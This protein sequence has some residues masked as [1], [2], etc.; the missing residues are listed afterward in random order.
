MIILRD[1]T[2][3]KKAQETLKNANIE[4]E[5]RVRE[6]TKEL[7]SLIEQSPLGIVIYNRKGNITEH[8]KSFNEILEITDESKIMF[9]NIFSDDYLIRNNYYLQLKNI[10]EEGGSL[11]TR[12]I[13]IS[14]FE[15]SIYQ[16]NNP[17]WLKFRFYSIQSNDEK[18]QNVIGIIEDIT[19]QYRLEEV[20][21]KLIR[22]RAR[23]SAILEATENERKRISMDLHDG[24]GQILTSA[25]LK[26]E[27]FK[28]KYKFPNEIIN[29]ALELI[30]KAGR[31]IS[32][33]VHNLH[34]IEIDKYGLP[35]SIELLCEKIEKTRKIKINFKNENYIPVK[36]KK[37]ELA[38]FRIVQESLNNIAKHSKAESAAI[39]LSRNENDECLNNH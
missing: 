6:K 4:L 11:L 31:E 28:L 3:Y 35:A 8:N 36:D 13:H 38:L 16:N 21:R 37:I 18:I 19:E 12:S 5:K 24:L 22:N 30:L 10:F 1:V 23:T 14:K 20:T 39:K 7:S 9:Y 33:I 17:K 29:E 26:L 27:I 32:D 34:P 2:I 15:N 25:K